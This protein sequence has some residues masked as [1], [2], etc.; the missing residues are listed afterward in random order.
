MLLYL[1]GPD[2]YRRGKA[3]RDKIVGPY[4][5]KYPDGVTE[6]FYCSQDGEVERLK[7]FVSTQGLF[8]K[9]KLG[10]IYEA[11]DAEKGLSE[12]LK[13]ALDDKATTL[14][15]IADKK[16]PKEFDFLLKDPVSS[17]SFESLSG[18]QFTAFL[19]KE[20][21]AQELKVSDAVIRTT[22]EQ[23]E[24]DSWGAITELQKL[25]FGASAEARANIPDFFPLIQTLKSGSTQSRLKAL[26]HVLEN[27]EPAVVFNMLAS[28]VGAAVKIKMAN[29]D[30]AI[31]SGKLEYEEA[32]FDFVLTS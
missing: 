28:L 2:S 15:V 32:L 9:T 18:S 22:G 3:L 30:V 26:W 11:N 20:V 14:V 17:Y 21:G 12:I 25:A 19:K 4:Q 24:G 16:L 29:Y 7:E 31:K 8:A 5:K 27:N 6:Q 23:Y 1:Y 13:N 10:V